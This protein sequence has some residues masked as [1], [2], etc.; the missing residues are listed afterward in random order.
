MHFIQPDWPAPARIKAYTTLR[1][2]WG[3]PDRPYKSPDS[4][5]QLI[6]L[7][8][9]PNE[10]LWLTQTHSAIAVEALP[11]NINANA[12]ACYTKH[13]Q[14]ICTILT[15][16]CLP[17]L[18][19]N[20]QGTAVAAIHAGWR[21]LAN[22]VIEAALHALN[23]PARD[24]LVWLGPAIGPHKF[25]VGQDVYTAFTSHHSESASAFTPCTTDK[26]LAD[27]YALATMRLGLLGITNI[28]GG[29][30][31]TYTEK[32]KFFSYRRDGSQTGRMAS[33]I[34]ID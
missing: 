6:S 17:L 12:D 20:Q 2:A 14:H 21:G 9:L 26:W 33:V 22:G 11:N 18:V 32:D 28:Y 8:T 31:C 7:L 3:N 10:P 23:E 5:S 25:E 34:W 29:Q 1:T 16:D 24:L 30:H 4:T 13:K 27:L 19:C 15:A